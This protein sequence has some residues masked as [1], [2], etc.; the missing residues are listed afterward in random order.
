M[1]GFDASP[2]GSIHALEESAVADGLAAMD[3]VF[4]APQGEVPMEDINLA[5]EDITDA[6][7]V[8]ILGEA[9]ATDSS[10]AGIG[11]EPASDESV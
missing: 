2:L 1:G 11:K 9:T 4:D 8:V 10:L 3:T 6:V 5:V 7:D